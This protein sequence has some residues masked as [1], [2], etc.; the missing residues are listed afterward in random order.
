M[1]IVVAADEN[2]SLTDYILNYLK[3]KNHEIILLGDLKEKNGKWVE[4]G[5]EAAKMVADKKVD[6]GVIFCWSGT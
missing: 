1:K 4:I 3:S 5:L 2:T 6:Q